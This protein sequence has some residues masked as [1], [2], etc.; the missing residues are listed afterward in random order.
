MG[1]TQTY[2]HVLNRGSKASRARS[3]VIR[4]FGASGHHRRLHSALLMT[5]QRIKLR[6][7]SDVS[8]GTSL[9]QIVE[10]NNKVI[11]SVFHF[12]V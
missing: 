5:L 4:A 8:Y 11:F 3:S 10:S 6:L 1:A 2:T 9:G 12:M 7:S